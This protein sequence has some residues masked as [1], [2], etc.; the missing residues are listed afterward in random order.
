MKEKGRLKGGD[1]R[2]LQ[3]VGLI[4]RDSDYKCLRI[5]ESE[6]VLEVSMDQV[7]L[8]FLSESGYSFRSCTGH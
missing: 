6:T 1:E 8:V 5:T 3:I 7:D 2:G 4:S